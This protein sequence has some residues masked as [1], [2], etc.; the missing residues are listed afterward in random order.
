MNDFWDAPTIT[1]FKLTK[2]VDSG[3]HQLIDGEGYSGES[4]TGMARA[5]P[6]GFSSNPPAGA[7]GYA[8]RMGS[9][10]RLLALGFETPGR[11]RDLVAGGGVLY[12]ADGNITFCRMGDGVLVRAVN[13][14][15]TIERGPMRVI[16]SED[17]VDLGGPGGEQVVTV[18]GPSSKVFAIL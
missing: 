5:Q 18:A 11:P 16:I 17:R 12:D 2:A 15:V 7:V 13:G 10:D 6:H 8:L 1:R 4:F 14:T 3:D 9:S